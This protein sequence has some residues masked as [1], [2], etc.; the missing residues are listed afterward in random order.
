MPADYRNLPGTVRD[1][2]ERLTGRPLT[3]TA[4]GQL[5]LA[6]GELI[7]VLAI[8]RHL[9]DDVNHILAN[10]LPSSSWARI[11]VRDYADLEPRRF[12]ARDQ[13]LR[14]VRGD[15][16]MRYAPIG[17]ADTDLVQAIADHESA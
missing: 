2:W 15:V 17:L 7:A 10:T 4:E 9:A 1:S 5:D 6:E 14:R 3:V 12:A 16:R 8:S 13:R 11:A